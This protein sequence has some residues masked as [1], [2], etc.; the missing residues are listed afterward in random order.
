VSGSTDTVAPRPLVS[1]G[2]PVY[3][4]DRFLKRAL[5]SL[6]GQTL[7]DFELIISDNASTDGTQAIGEDYAR[8]DRRVRYIRQPTNLGAPR[9]WNVVA[10]EARGVFFKWASGSDYCAPVMLEKCVAAMQADGAVVLCYGRT[11]LVDEHEQPLEVYES[12][13]AFD[14][15]RPSER[16]ARV[17]ALMALNNA[18]CGVIR[19]DSLRLTRL[20]RLYPSGDMA[21]MAELSLY[22][23]FRLVPEVL[24]FRRQSTGT[25]TSML[26]PLERQRVYDPGAKAPMAFIR[27]RRHLDNIVSIARAP[28]PAVE[29]FRAYR[30]ELRQLR[31]DRVH[32]WRELL[33]LFAGSQSAA[34]RR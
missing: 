26:T 4:A 8:R 24:L 6:L 34:R 29:K 2:V 18:Q 23:K 31:W 32:L 19:R 22:G 7:S 27:G 25:F 11:Q 16:F 28:V 3:N 15:D 20:D 30:S 17:S 5:D 1:I 33:S 9:N 13:L 21:L 10:R 14:E 12:D